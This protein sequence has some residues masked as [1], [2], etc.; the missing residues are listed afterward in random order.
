MRQVQTIFIRTPNPET[1]KQDA[2]LMEF[3]GNLTSEKRHAIMD[4]AGV[5]INR[6][7]ARGIIAGRNI[8]RIDLTLY[9]DL[10]EAESRALMDHYRSQVK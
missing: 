10:D 6:K 8:Y 9:V 2:D 3:V 7:P 1:R 4:T 5:T